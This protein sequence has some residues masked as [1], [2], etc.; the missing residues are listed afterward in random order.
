M[1]FVKHEPFAKAQGRVS[2]AIAWNG[3]K[4]CGPIAES[5]KHQVDVK[6]AKE[7]RVIGHRLTFP[8]FQRS[9]D[10]ARERQHEPREALELVSETPSGERD[11][12]TDPEAAGVLHGKPR[13]V[14]G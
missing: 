7:N 12:E 13:P 1:K 2:A 8:V 5:R 3:P 11:S 4:H 14:Q 10:F 6:K 9:T